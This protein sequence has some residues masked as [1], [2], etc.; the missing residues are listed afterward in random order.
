MIA[1][2]NSFDMTYNFD[3]VKVRQNILLLAL[4]AIPQLGTAQ[5]NVSYEIF[6]HGG[7]GYH[8]VLVNLKSDSISPSV[9]LE[10]R[11]TA[12]SQMVSAEPPAVAITGTF[13]H[14]T[15]A[16][17]V[18]DVLVDGR[19]EASGMRGSVLAV[20]WFGGVKM[21]DS[22][23]LQPIDWSPY[24]FALRGLVRL[25]KN[26][27]VVPNPKAQRFRDPRIWGKASRCA[28]GIRKDGKMI[29]LVTRNNVTLTQLGNAMKSRGV[30]EA[31]NLDGG[32]STALW[33][34]GK[35]VISPGRRLSNLFMIYERAP[36]TVPNEFNFVHNSM[37]RNSW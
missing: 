34:K 4:C 25:I 5:S 23:F 28:A 12:L 17:P 7:A 13:F 11:P 3:T 6:K 33:Y 2:Q 24:R 21:W 18:G 32:G 27:A 30:V 15:S 8:S 36:I 31:V 37:T 20:D 29:L 16:Y 1:G 26:G 19:L 22:G 10:N 14:P 9:M 35:S